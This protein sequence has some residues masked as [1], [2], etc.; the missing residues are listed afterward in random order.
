MRFDAEEGSS[1]S[2]SGAS[3]IINNCSEYE[4]VEIFRTFSGEKYA[5]DLAKCIVEQRQGTKIETTGDLKRVISKGF[6]LGDDD[7]SNSIIRRTFQALRIATNQELLN[8]KKF[9]EEC[10][11]RIMDENSLLLVITFHSLEER[12]VSQQF[13]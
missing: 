6:N 3:A 2:H 11:E 10:P 5:G 7:G 8:L 1:D 9:L 4:L 12:I 13:Q